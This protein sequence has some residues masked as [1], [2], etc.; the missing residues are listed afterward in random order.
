MLRLLTFNRTSMELKLAIGAVRWRWRRLLI[1]PVWNWNADSFSVHGIAGAL[2][3]EPVW[4]WNTN[5]NNK[6]ASLDSLLIEPVWNWNSLCQ[7]LAHCGHA[8]LIEPVWNWNHELGVYATNTNSTF[9]RTSM[10]LKRVS[11][12]VRCGAVALLIEPVW[13]WN[14]FWANSPNQ[15][16][17]F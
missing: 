17:T 4:N 7:P 8:L 5:N 10:E 3:I 11:E 6:P 12:T 2:L 15:S 9:N 1:E 16:K 13:N 14:K